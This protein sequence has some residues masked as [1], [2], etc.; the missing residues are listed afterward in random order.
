M[1]WA[2]TRCS[3]LRMQQVPSNKSLTVGWW[4]NTRAVMSA[5]TVYNKY[6]ERWLA[7]HQ[8]FYYFGHNLMIIPTGPTKMSLAPCF[9]F[10]NWKNCLNCIFN[11]KFQIFFFKNSSEFYLEQFRDV[12]TSPK[13]KYICFIFDHWCKLLCSSSAMQWTWFLGIFLLPLT[14]SSCH[15]P[16][17]FF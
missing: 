6:W 8:L 2:L 15:S 1:S 11:S 9:N 13:S 14:Q 10:K 7:L 17:K 3:V 5:W 12:W 4:R 16:V